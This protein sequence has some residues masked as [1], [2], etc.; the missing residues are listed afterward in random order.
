MAAITG[1]ASAGA[2]AACVDTAAGVAFGPPQQ[3]DP[4]EG[5]ADDGQA[6]PQAHQRE[7][8]SGLRR[9]QDPC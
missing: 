9:E 2:A 1:G 5:D 3:F 7:P 6:H 4:G 8:A